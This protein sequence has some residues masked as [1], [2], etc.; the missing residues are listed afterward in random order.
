MMS[1]HWKRNWKQGATILSLLVFSAASTPL[2]R[3]DSESPVTQRSPRIGTRS[4]EQP[5]LQSVTPALNATDIRP[6][7]KVVYQFNTSAKDYRAWL[8][9]LG[10]GRDVHAYLYDGTNFMLLPAK[11]V[12]VDALLGTVVVNHPVL[13]RYSEYAV[14]LTQ[15]PKLLGR[16]DTYTDIVTQ[17]DVAHGTVTLLGHGTI[18]LKNP[19]DK[20]DTRDLQGLQVGDMVDVH[21]NRNG[22]HAHLDHRYEHALVTFSRPDQP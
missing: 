1:R 18:T 20:L 8:H 12:Q 4:L 5:I 14:V 17:V 16:G 15:G 11:R 21:I 3:A 7:A 13:R 19:D 9:Q 22:S 10:Q 2:A 6:D